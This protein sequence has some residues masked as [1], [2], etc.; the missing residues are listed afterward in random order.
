MPRVTMFDH[1]YEPMSVLD[2]RDRDL[3]LLRANHGNYFEI[4]AAHVERRYAAA[5]T[6]AMLDRSRQW[7][8]MLLVEGTRWADGLV[9]PM[10][11]VK[12]ARIRDLCLEGESIDRVSLE[13]LR[14]AMHS[15]SRYGWENQRLVEN[16]RINRWLYEDMSRLMAMPP[17]SVQAMNANW[18]T[19]ALVDRS[20]EEGAVSSVAPDG[21]EAD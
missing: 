21:A 20:Q 12:G 14:G 5:T 3:Q 18:A 1:E 8:L 9:R 19:R 15:A 7:R 4:A 2:V 6:S 16:D 11:V 17:R 10:L 13:I